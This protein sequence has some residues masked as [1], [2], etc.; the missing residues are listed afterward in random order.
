MGLLSCF[1]A[2]HNLPNIENERIVSSEI[3]LE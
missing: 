1:Y 3:T 2:V